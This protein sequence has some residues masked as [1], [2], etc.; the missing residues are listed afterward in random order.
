MDEVDQIGIMR[1]RE[2]GS[3]RPVHALGEEAP[4]HRRP[5]VGDSARAEARDPR[6]VEEL[7]EQDRNGWDRSTGQARRPVLSRAR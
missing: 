2:E 4:L 6:A 7:D 3:V 1:Q 5:V